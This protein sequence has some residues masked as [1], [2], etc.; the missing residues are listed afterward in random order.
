MESLIGPIAA[1]NCVLLKP[2]EATPHVERLL[3]TRLPHYIDSRALGIVSGGPEIA[4]S[5]IER[6]RF[7]HILFTGSR[8]VARSIC[9]STKQVG[10]NMTPLTLSLGGKCPAILLKSNFTDDSILRK[11]ISKILY[12]KIANCGM[13]ASSPDYVLLPKGIGEK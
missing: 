1:G 10:S 4:K 8:E 11:Q 5:L 13:L 2:S 6:F 12:G 3:V 7:D 9:C